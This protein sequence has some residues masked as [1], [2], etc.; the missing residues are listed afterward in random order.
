[1]SDDTDDDVIVGAG[2]SV[3][4]AVSR[5]TTNDLAI[6]VAEKAADLIRSAS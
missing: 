1:M 3:L 2:R 5:G 4:P 6:L